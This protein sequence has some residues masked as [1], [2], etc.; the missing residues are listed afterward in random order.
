[1]MSIKSRWMRRP[2]LSGSI[3][4]WEAKQLSAFPTLL[5][6]VTATYTTIHFT[7]MTVYLSSMFAF[8]LLAHMAN[9]KVQWSNK[10]PQK[11]NVIS[12]GINGEKDTNEWS[13][14]PLM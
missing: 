11:Q 6:R 14:M 13:L 2:E 3:Q 7:T 12:E 9:W 8:K 5:Y 10:E 4:F 1:M